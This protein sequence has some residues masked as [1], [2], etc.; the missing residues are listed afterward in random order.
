MSSPSANL[1][2]THI[3][4]ETGTYSL[5]PSDDSS[6][7]IYIKLFRTISSADFFKGIQSHVGSQIFQ[8]CQ[9][10]SLGREVSYML[11][12][13]KMNHVSEK[14]RKSELCGE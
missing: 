9:E 5:E 8:Q 2:Q 1:Q 7:L 6:H 3:R 13:V 10:K 12:L 11:Q 14:W 4:L